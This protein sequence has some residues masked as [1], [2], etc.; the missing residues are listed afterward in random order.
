MLTIS[1]LTLFF[2]P[3]GFLVCLDFDFK[4]FSE[5]LMSTL[6][7]VFLHVRNDSQLPLCLKDSLHGHNVLKSNYLSLKIFK[8]YYS[9]IF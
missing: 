6:F 5:L 3:H 9:T 1:L 2:F 4:C 8:K 7:L